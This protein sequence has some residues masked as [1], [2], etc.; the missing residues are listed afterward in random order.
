MR[1]E[2]LALLTNLA[3]EARDAAAKLLA[4]KQRDQ[5]LI[6]VQI[7]Q[8]VAYRLEYRNQ[9]HG[10]ATEGIELTTLRE[11]Q[12]FL[13]MLDNAIQQ[14][15]EKLAKHE[16]SVVQHRE[17]WREKQ[18]QLV[19]YDTLAARLNAVQRQGEQRREQRLHDDI[20]VTLMSRT[21]A[22]ANASD[23]NAQE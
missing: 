10:L 4:T 23:P 6:S 13:A 21:S 11:F 19:G 17:S 15:Q 12:R 9:L 2:S 7:D 5:R 16:Q 22:F 18:Q 14:A 3:R 8:L 20:S 1:K